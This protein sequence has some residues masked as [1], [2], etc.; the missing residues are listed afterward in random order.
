MYVHAHESIRSFSFED[1]GKWFAVS[2][3][4]FRNLLLIELYKN[5]TRKRKDLS[6]SKPLRSDG[7]E[8]HR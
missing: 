1:C 2:G 5:I 3:G 4:R 7:D 8:K 6:K